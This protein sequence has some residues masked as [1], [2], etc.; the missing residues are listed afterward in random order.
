MSL[1][2]APCRA[3]QEFVFDL[4]SLHLHNTNICCSEENTAN[5]PS[6]RYPASFLEMVELQIGSGPEDQH[7]KMASTTTVGL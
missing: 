2:V 5:E 4:I 7:D 3:C 1:T 6:Q